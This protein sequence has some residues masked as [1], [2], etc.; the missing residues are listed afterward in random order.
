MISHLGI[1]IQE[2]ALIISILILSISLIDFYFSHIK[3]AISEV[4]LRPLEERHG[5][6]NNKGSR[7]AYNLHFNAINHGDI[8]GWLIGGEVS[9]IEFT[10]SGKN[11][12][13]VDELPG[14]RVRFEFPTQNS[15]IIPKNSTVPL[16]II[17]EMGPQSDIFELTRTHDTATFH[18]HIR[19]EDREH[20][21][22]I[23]TAN[24]PDNLDI[25][26]VTIRRSD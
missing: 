18:I 24:N 10:K 2:G 20:Q 14:S 11:P 3:S 25:S 19:I 22:V 7:V 23:R 26:G 1:S 12:R 6:L 15:M 21:Y 13:I 5:T 9:K 17:P 8:D 16:T 4:E